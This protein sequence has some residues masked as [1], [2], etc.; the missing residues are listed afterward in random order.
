M[1]ACAMCLGTDC[2]AACEQG[3]CYA[4]EQRLRDH[5]EQERREWEDA[6]MARLYSK[7]P[8]G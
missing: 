1:R 5:L 8:H 6:E 3:Q 2:Q 7:H 4:E